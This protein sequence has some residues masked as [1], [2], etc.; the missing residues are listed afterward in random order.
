MK[1]L[2]LHCNTLYI[3]R[4]PDIFFRSSLKSNNRC[5]GLFSNSVVDQQ[6]NQSFQA[7]ANISV[8]VLILLILEQLFEILLVLNIYGVHFYMIYIFQ[9][10]SCQS[11]HMFLT[12]ICGDDNVNDLPTSFKSVNCAKL[13]RLKIRCSCVGY[14]IELLF[15]L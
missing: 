2:G 4:I 8:R 12:F 15:K 3:V 14:T 10:F 7:Y 5:R 1:Y 9:F 6:L 13:N 11:K